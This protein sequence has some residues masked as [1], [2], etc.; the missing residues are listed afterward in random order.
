MF[1]QDI[2]DI[3]EVAEDEHGVGTSCVAL[4]N[5]CWELH[6]TIEKL[7]ANIPKLAEVAISF[8]DHSTEEFGPND[9][10]DD[11]LQSAL[12]AVGIHTQLIDNNETMVI[13]V[14]R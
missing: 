9:Y 7:E 3:D 5:E 11:E 14:E 13:T 1:Y 2:K 8:R 4:Y 12:L 10:W 6:R